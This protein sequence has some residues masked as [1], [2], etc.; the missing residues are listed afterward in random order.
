MPSN[1]KCSVFELSSIATGH[2]HGYKYTLS[3]GGKM[4]YYSLNASSRT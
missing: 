4:R 2:L 3:P 1:G